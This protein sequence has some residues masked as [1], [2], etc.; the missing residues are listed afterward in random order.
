MNFNLKRRPFFFIALALVGGLL[1]TYLLIY[2]KLFLLLK[3]ILMF[4]LL[5]LFYFF[6]FRLNF[7]KDDIFIFLIILF[8]ILGTILFT[9]QEY[10]LQSK[11]SLNKIESQNIK[12]IAKLYFDLGDLEGDTVYLKPYFING[13]KIKY[14]KIIIHSKKLDNFNDGDLISLELEL[15]EIDTAL[16]PGS[17]SYAK[18]L[19]K[20]G[21][22]KQGWE[23]EKINLIQKSKSIKNSLISFKK[24]LLTNIDY[25]FSFKNGAFIK[26][27]L[28]G[29]REDLNFT[30]KDLLKNAG[31]S[32]LLAISGLHM[33]II[34]LS[35]SYLLFKI[36]TSKKMALYFLSFLIFIYIIL[37]GA[38]VSI[39][40][41]ALLALL[42]LWA[43][44]FNREADF[45]NIIALTLIINLVINP[46][47]LFTV[48]LQLSY[49][50]VLALFYLT[51]IFKQRLPVFLAVSLVAQLASIAIAGYYFNQYSYISLITNLWLIPYISLLLPFIFT[52]VFLSIFSLNL[53]LP[54]VFLIECLLNYLF[55]G[56]KLM[57]ILQGRPLVI[58]KLNLITVIFYYILL[59]SLAFL[60]RKY[61]IQLNL[62][63]I[64]FWR[65]IVSLLLLMLISS[66][67]INFNSNKLEINFVAVGQGD[68]IFIQFPG[69]ENMLIDTGP[70]GTK[71]RNIEY[72]I[73]SYLNYLGVKKIDYF[74]VS[75]F[76]AD[77]VGGIEHL[78]K[79]KKV[80][81][82]LIPPFTEKTTFHS[83]LNQKIKEKKVKANY[84]T[85]GMV[86]KLGNCKIEILNPEPNQIHSD[87]N[88][89]SIVFLLTHK[90]NSFLFTGDLSQAGEERIVKKYDLAHV[91]VLKAG[92]HGSKTSSGQK[93]LTKIKP[94]LAIICVGKNNFGHPAPV[95]LN[96]FKTNSIRYLRTDQNGLIK[97][98]SDGSQ[99]RVRTFK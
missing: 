64:L 80:K 35:F 36:F 76:D 91:D 40:R 49:I 43:S 68:G 1:T 63:K 73:I 52:L 20:K 92:H 95:V 27:I 85:A 51:P 5:F 45:L 7:S 13:Q 9:Y 55:K 56:L 38:A 47:A 17:F 4:E 30:Q 21:V 6:I 22:Y 69:S 84:L 59:F 58:G 19:R 78:F 88:E 72:N 26:A 39:I 57:T 29:E 10:K 46:L 75:H 2:L 42:F 94:D 11:F 96:R 33:G 14:G 66:F 81:N 25:L 98:I 86:F 18:Y 82:V 79:R 24:I 28:L 37:V 74:L 77:H 16:N 54:L 53:I 50:L 71:G 44:E 89:N 34:I 70:P 65:K 62:N 97:I 99:I 67:F 83:F 48:S 90:N 61:Y 8:F 12:L 60:Y 31:A 23:L 41:A 3:V 87:R 32:H 93:L 15:S